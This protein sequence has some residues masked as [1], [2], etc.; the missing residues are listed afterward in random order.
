MNI[1]IRLTLVLC[2]LTLQGCATGMLTSY[3]K[4]KHKSDVVYLSKWK[5]AYIDGNILTV[6]GEGNN[7]T[8]IARYQIEENDSCRMSKN[9]EHAY[10]LMPHGIEVGPLSASIK[11]TPVVIKVIKDDTRELRDICFECDFGRIVADEAT[12]F[13]LPKSVTSYY[14]NLGNSSNWS[15]YIDGSRYFVLC[16]PKHQCSYTTGKYR[17][18]LLIFTPATVV[19]DIV[20][21][22]VQAVLFV[23]V[24]YT[25]NW[26]EPFGG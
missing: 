22:P 17:K 7:K 24:I 5:Q 10:M 16:G 3:A 14:N 9:R 25:T 12:L 2:I 4:E 8:I 21:L 13:V 19:I 26:A 11:G 18:F 1:I 6:V 20:T 23:V 15:L